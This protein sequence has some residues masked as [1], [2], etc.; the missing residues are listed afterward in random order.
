MIRLDL[1]GP[2]P[3]GRDGLAGRRR[4]PGPTRW[5][6]SE[7]LG[8]AAEAHLRCPGL[9]PARADPIADRRDGGGWDGGV[10]RSDGGGE[11][12]GLGGEAGVCSGGGENGVSEEGSGDMSGDVRCY[13]EGG[14]LGEAAVLDGMEALAAMRAVELARLRADLDR[15]VPEGAGGGG[16][17]GGNVGGRE[18]GG[19][20]RAGLG[21]HGREGLGVAE[22]GGAGLFGPAGGRSAPLGCFPPSTV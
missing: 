3:A 19:D 13:G 8:P 12:G 2:G 22:L 6:F 7:G 15:S 9:G 4:Q 11:A 10:E 1:D 16:Y 17:A 14:E 21:S 20:R 18:K 5:S